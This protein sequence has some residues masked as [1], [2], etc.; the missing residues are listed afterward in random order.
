[1]GVD[2][3]NKPSP[4]SRANRLRRVVWGLVYTSLFRPSPR[5]CH[6]W[7]NMLLRLFGARLHRKARVYP[8][9]KI[10]GPWNLEMAEHATLAD[11]VDCYCVDRI[12]IGAHT[13]VSQY[14]YLCGATHDHEHPRF[15]LQPRPIVIGS[16]RYPS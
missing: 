10:W 16:V 2:I 15:P 8:R 4:H 1:M 3:S 7:R 9:A 5:P 12:T 14:S 11:D 13:T 6:A